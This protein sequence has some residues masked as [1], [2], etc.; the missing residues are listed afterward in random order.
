MKILNYTYMK[1]KLFALIAVVAMVMVSCE[2]PPYIAAPGNNDL[3]Q[4]DTIPEIAY[5]DPTPDAEG[6]DVPDST[7][8]VYEAR[9][10]CSKLASGA[11]TDKEYYVKGWVC[12]FDEKHA[13]GIES[14]GNGTFY[15]AATNDGKTNDVPFE[16]YQVM[17]KDGKKLTID[18]VALGDFVVIKGILTN[19]NGTYETTGKGAAHIYSSSNPYFGLEPVIDTTNVTPDPEGVDVPEGAITVYRARAISDSIG[20]GNTTQEKYYIKGWV[21]RI[22]SKHADGVNQYGN[23]TFYITPT[24]DGTTE[25]FTFEAFQVYGKDGKKLTSPDQVEVGDFVVLYGQITNFKGTAETTGKGTAYI[26]SSSNEKFNEAFQPADPTKITPDPEGADVPEGTLT[27]YEAL[28]IGDSIGSGKTTTDEYYIKGWVSKLHSTH[29]SGV[30][31]YGNGTFFI[32]PT[33][34]GTTASITFEAYQVYGKNKQKLTSA[35]Q[36]AVGDFVVLRGKIT[37]YNG[38]VETVGRGAAYIYYSTNEK[39]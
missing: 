34:D 32:T 12:Q 5:P 6:V 9:K 18:E 28:H 27:V 25:S 15:I 22:D 14:F 17:G 2:E 38:T 33:N 30:T 7:L 31:S 19:Y 8:N 3:V 16:A 20:S 4:G 11:T 23:G 24:N 13:S 37:N 21:S 26:Y 29:A 35:D 36:V 1:T 39:W 10:L